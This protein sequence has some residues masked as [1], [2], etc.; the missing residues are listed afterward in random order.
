MFS[1]A[2]D[3]KWVTG[4]WL[5]LLVLWQDTSFS[6]NVMLE[7]PP[8]PHPSPTS[9]IYKAF[10][11]W[12][13]SQQQTTF[14]SCAVK[15]LKNCWTKLLPLWNE[16]KESLLKVNVA[17]LWI[18]DCVLTSANNC[19]NVKE[20]N[21]CVNST[22]LLYKTLKLVRKG[23]RQQCSSHPC[24]SR[25]NEYSDWAWLFFFFLSL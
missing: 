3:K 12:R 21:A 2:L 22:V 8:H 7:T 10:T 15:A 14:Q 4:K 5:K 19:I 9:Q 24:L 18:T 16:L 25:R 6:V 20:N 17:M 1:C 23:L 13:K 11:S